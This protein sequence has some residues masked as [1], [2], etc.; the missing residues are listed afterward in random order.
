MGPAG[1]G[2]PAYQ[3]QLQQEA[4]ELRSAVL[5][6]QRRLYDSQQQLAKSQV[7]MN[8]VSEFLV[9]S[10]CRC[11]CKHALIAFSMWL[12]LLSVGLLFICK[13]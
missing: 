9:L 4:A 10:Q 3:L 1:Q 13:Q 11:T 7:R 2:A 8:G 5:A 6:A 12:G